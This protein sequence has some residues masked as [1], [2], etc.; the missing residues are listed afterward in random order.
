MSKLPFIECLTN[1]FEM[2]KNSKPTIEYLE[3]CCKNNREW[4]LKRINYFPKES[5]SYHLVVKPQ[6]QVLSVL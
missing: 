1:T 5:L 3:C 2:K 4:K 6:F